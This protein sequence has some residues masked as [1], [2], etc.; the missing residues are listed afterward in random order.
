MVQQE[1]P[2]TYRAY[3]N[4]NGY[5]LES[6]HGDVVP[7]SIQGQDPSEILPA[8]LVTISSF[9]EFS[10]QD[11]WLSAT[12][13]T[14]D[15]NNAF[16]YADV[17]P[18]QG[19][20]DGDISVPMT[21]DGVFDYQLTND[22]VTTTP[23]NINAAIVNLFVM[24][25]FLHDYYYDFGFDEA[26]GNAQQDNFG[27]GGVDGDQ[28]FVEAQDFS[29][30]N[31]ANMATPADGANPRMQQFLWNSKDALDGVD[32]GVIVT[33]PDIGTLPSATASFGAT[34]YDVTADVVRIIDE[35]GDGTVNDG[36]EVAVNADA[37]AG[38]IAIIDRGQCPF[39]QKALNAQA[40][41]AVGAIIVNN[42]DDGTPA[43]V[44]G[45]DAAVTIPTRG[46]NFQ[47]GGL[48]YDVID[49]G[50]VATTRIFENF[51]LKDSTFDNGIIAHEFGH[52]IQNRLVGNAS[53][54]G[55]FQG[56]AMGEGW[57]DFHGLLFIALESDAQI[58]GNEQFQT[59]YASGTFVE[60]FFTGIRRAAYSTDR[61]INPLTFTNIQSGSVPPGLP[62]TNVG[63]PHAPGELWAV[64]L[65]D[66]YVGLINT[67]GF[68]EAQDRMSGYVIAGLK[69]TPINPLYTEARDA[70][71][72]AVLGESQE[73]FD[74]AVQAF[75]ARGLG[76]G[77][78][79]PPR[80]STDLIGAVESF[81]TELASFA[82]NSLSLQADFV[83]DAGGFC[84]SD[85]ILD[86]GETGAVN[87]N[88]TNN[89]SESL[90]GLTAQLIVVGADGEPLADQ[91]VVTF[92]ND[93]VVELPALEPFT[94]AN[95]G[96]IEVTLN[97]AQAAEALNLRVVFNEAVEGDD[98]VESPDLNLSVFVNIDFSLA[99]LDGV[100]ASDNMESITLFEDWQQNILV[101]G[102][103][104]EETQTTDSNNTAFFQARNPDVDLGTQTQLFNNNTFESDVSFETR[105][106]TVAEDGE[107]SV[108][109]WHF[110][111]IE[112]G[113]DG[114]VVEVSID[115]GD[116][117]DVT[118]AGGVF[119][120]GY[121]DADTTISDVL[122]G[123]PAFTGQNAAPGFPVGETGNTESINFGD[124]LNGSD[125]R[126]RFRMITDAAVGSFGW[127]VDN[128]TFN[129]ISS[130]VFSD[131]IAGDDAS[132][133]CDITP[134]NIIL[135]N[136][137]LDVLERGTGEF[138]A[139]LMGV[140]DSLL[141]G[142]TFSWEQV[143][144]PD[145]LSLTGADTDS[146][147][148]IPPIVSEDTDVAFELTVTGD[149]NSAT[150]TARATI[151][152]TVIPADPPPAEPNVNDTG[153]GSA[154]WLSL[155]LLP[156]TFIRRR[157]K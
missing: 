103:R 5:P 143:E 144:G 138:T 46:L 13:T 30:L 98:I 16:A 39:T 90:S 52:Y 22:E 100:E 48:I 87:F 6:P 60:D 35:G 15:G 148:F 119:E 31:N 152:N 54:L 85:G 123:R 117:T 1:S 105:S 140:D 125:V 18:P 133:V 134:L 64:S 156:L 73:D 37:L 53:G 78:V 130:Q 77:A 23:N 41:G 154:G 129:N 121:P 104:A 114:G 14:T 96:P 75:A 38:N 86:V 11:P 10:M 69:L 9:A 112:L 26:S 79:S 32:F 8:P 139:T 95:V 124:T 141:D 56:R 88:M 58:P 106:F 149:N 20:S 92:E 99:E 50:D 61:A 109:F 94:Q 107:F 97:Q 115:G 83:G 36:C 49:G 147:S 29:G 155:L 17:V 33:A 126:F 65:W 47:N 108:D 55:N 43:P 135:D 40:A 131:I 145:V 102:E 63:S 12:A 150:V 27:R 113:F 66:I 2:I 146:I 74:L 24:N 80:F 28:L 128:V 42:I 19:F 45:T 132:V 120:V 57:A 59:N 89:G 82:T 151:I 68:E 71:L 116:W 3:L 21:S 101:G 153:S 81:E 142:I 127:F 7:T 111:G 44:G 91:S 122:Q 110:Y 72:V 67:H 93:G 4:D 70:F 157:R 118:E 136:T 34:Q 76:F 25:N 84:T 137:E 51:L 62:P